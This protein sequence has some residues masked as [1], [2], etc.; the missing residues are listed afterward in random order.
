[1]TFV[2]TSLPRSFPK[3]QERRR[4]IALEEMNAR[5]ARDGRVS[6]RYDDGFRGAV[7]M[8]PAVVAFIV[9]AVLVS[10]SGPMDRVGLTMVGCGA[11]ILSF[12]AYLI[13]TH[14]VFA[15][16]PHVELM[17]ITAAQQRR[18]PSRLARGLG[19]D[20]AENLAVSVAFAAL[21]GA[22]AA[23]ALGGREGGALLALLALLTAATAWITV[24]Y[25]FALR[26]LRLH[27]A[28][29]RFR[30]EFEDAPEFSDFLA[31][32][33]MISSA[34]ALSASTPVTRA[35]VRAVRS[36]AVIAFTFNALV[37]AM[38][39]SLITGLVTTLG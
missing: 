22:V 21:A 33:L 36:H 8:G 24:V 3:R 35:G 9:I 17:H 12:G 39:V 18:R 10:R 30:F 28:G 5:T 32:A 1:M 19:F 14:L 37:V 34:G 15:R 20:S 26:Y 2:R 6:L 31:T 25:A 38:I 13:W 23:A 11:M 4:R 27:A 7:T 16:T 29:E